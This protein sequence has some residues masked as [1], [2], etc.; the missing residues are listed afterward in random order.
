[1]EYPPLK[2]SRE[3]TLGSWWRLFGIGVVFALLAIAA[4]TPVG[5]VLVIVPL[6][7]VNVVEVGL[8]VIAA[9]L[10]PFFYA[11]SVLVYVDLRV[12]QEGYGTQ[13]LADDLSRRPGRM[14]P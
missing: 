13:E 14:A 7:S 4:A 8:G 12:R 6:A 10:I 1:M 11:G 3:L 9:L 5:I 2:R